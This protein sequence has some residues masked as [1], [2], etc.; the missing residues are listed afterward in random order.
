MRSSSIG[1]TRIAKQAERRQPVSDIWDGSKY[2]YSALE[3]GFLGATNN[4][5]LKFSV[6]WCNHDLGSMAKGA[7]RP[8]TFEQ[9][10]DYLIENYFSN[11]SDW[12]IDGSP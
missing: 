1:T 3:K 5:R 10:T 12:K 2:L 7:V 9:M 4:A 6:M 8:E 11:P